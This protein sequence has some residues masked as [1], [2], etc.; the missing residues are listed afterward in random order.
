MS[1]YL[2]DAPS[3]SDASDVDNDVDN[4][5]LDNL[6]LADRDDGP[7]MPFD[8]HQIIWWYVFEAERADRY[9]ARELRFGFFCFIA[10]ADR[11]ALWQGLNDWF[12]SETLAFTQHQ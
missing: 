10:L 6:S 8:L 9:R 4:L 3:R 5:S 12:D 2:V 7:N 1:R 11:E